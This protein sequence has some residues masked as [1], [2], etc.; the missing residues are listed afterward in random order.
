MLSHSRYC[1]AWILLISSA[2]YAADEREDLESL[3]V[4]GNAKSMQ[5]LGDIPLLSR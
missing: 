5:V 3:N 2:S 1:I 4:F